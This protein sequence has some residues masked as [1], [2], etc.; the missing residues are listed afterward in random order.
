[1]STPTASDTLTSAG[2]ALDAARAYLAQAKRAS[3]TAASGPHGLDPARIYAEQRRLHGFAWVATVVEGLTQLA[4]W[5]ERLDAAGRLGEGETLIL[6][7]GFGEYLAQLIGG[8]P[9]SQ[10]EF[11][12]PADLDVQAAADALRADPAVAECLTV[13]NTP[14]TRAR[15]AALLGEGWTADDGLGDET[16]DM[17][18]G[19]FRRFADERII[20]GAH[21]WHLA[22]VLIPDAIVGEMAE[23][24]VFG[25]CIAPEFGGL[26]MG[27]LAMCVVSEEL[28]RGWIAAG[29]LGTRSEIAGELIGANGTD[30]QKA[31]WL[32]PIAAGEVLPTA[33]SLTTR[34]DQ[35]ADGSWRITGAKTWITHAARSD[36]MTLLARSDPATPGHNG[37][38]MFLAVKTRGTAQT[39]F[40]DPGLTGGEIRVL[41]YRGMKEYELSFDG[42]AVAED[43]LLGG[44]PGAG[45]R[46]LM[47]TFEGARIQTA[48]RAVGVA[49]R[50]LDLALGYALQRRQ[51]ARPL[52]AFP[53]VSDKLAL[54]AVETVIARELTYFAARTKDLGDRCDIE[55]GM[56]KLLAARVA[57]SNADAGVQIHGGNGYALE[58]EISRILCDARILNIFEGAAEIQANVIARGLLGRQG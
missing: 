2:K 37:L 50:A 41:G 32:T 3:L 57:W 18:R 6:R 53:R 36:L 46:Q 10:N 39:P 8:V 11:A 26:G 31:R 40:P 45:F 52:I 15:L 14:E 58:F 12:R 34:A 49:R 20:P 33:V 7:I 16:L 48:A 44:A 21:G 19:Q 56:A 28:S 38:S 5:A 55:A 22:D 35:N 27:K 24:G 13:G 1:M 42:F 51:F 43:G 29:S 47:R 23:L 54:M 25:V 9:M 4:A 17:V 30:A